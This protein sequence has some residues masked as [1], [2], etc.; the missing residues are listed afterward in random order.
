MGQID[1]VPSSWNLTV[2]LIIR[3]FIQA[4]THKDIY[5]NISGTTEHMTFENI[6]KS[7]CFWS[8]VL[9]TKCSLKKY[10]RLDN[11]Q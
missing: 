2:K 8:F 11:I 5:I 3:H 7:I 4:L 1:W 6:R 10:I 9:V